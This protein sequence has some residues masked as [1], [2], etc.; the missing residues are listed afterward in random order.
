MSC[1]VD[2]SF[3]DGM[4]QCQNLE[5][6]ILILPENFKF[7]LSFISPKSLCL[8]LPVAMHVNIFRVY[9]EGCPGLIQGP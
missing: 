6:G 9:G 1:D 3:I 4:R 2:Q 5:R 8:P 7:F